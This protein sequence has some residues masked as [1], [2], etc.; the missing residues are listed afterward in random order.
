MD[1]ARK[2]KV[3]ASAA[4]REAREL[5]WA[6][7]QR[8]LLGLGLMLVSRLTGFVLPTSTK[9]VIDEVL[10]K[11]RTDLL[12]PIA[13]AVAAATVVQ[14]LTFF[15]FAGSIEKDPTILRPLRSPV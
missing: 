10:T 11:G 1:P 7:R 5:V 9:F 2:K 8:L 14:A 15:F 6:H 4:W 13:L 3:S 12:T